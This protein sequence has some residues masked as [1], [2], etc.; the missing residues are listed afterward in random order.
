MEL[1][2][3]SGIGENYVRLCKMDVQVGVLYSKIFNVEG[4]RYNEI[5]KK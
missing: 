2:R 5:I 4:T 3:K 1:G